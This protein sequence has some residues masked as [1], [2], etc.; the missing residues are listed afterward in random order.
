M[1]T[2][3]S[4]PGGSWQSK[5]RRAVA[6]LRHCATGLMATGCFANW[7]RNRSFHRI[8]TGPL[9]LFA[10]VAFLLSEGL[11]IR[12][13]TA[14]VWPVVVI[15]TGIAFSLEWRYAKRSAL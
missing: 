3:G 1:Q 13:Y 6:R 12:V 4:Q 11:M 7:T 9:F 2:N 8:I 5:W 10:G 15:G 14:W